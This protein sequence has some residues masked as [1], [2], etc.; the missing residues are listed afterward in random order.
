MKEYR[1]KAVAEN[2]EAVIDFINSE[3]EPYNISAKIRKQIDM[4]VEEIYVNICHYAYEDESGEVLIQA[5]TTPDPDTIMIRFVDEGIAYN[6]LMRE[7]PDI[8]KPLREKKPG[9]L[10]I[11]IVKNTMDKIEYFYKDDKNDLTIWKLLE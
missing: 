7:D 2:V 11:Y 5:D 4:A 9:G 6:P 3:L 1:T 10:G 8:H